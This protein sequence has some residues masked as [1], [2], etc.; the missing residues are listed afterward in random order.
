MS[1]SKFIFSIVLLLILVGGAVA[2]YYPRKKEN[3]KLS[4]DYFPDTAEIPVSYLPV[5]GLNNSYFRGGDYKDLVD[6]P[7][8]PEPPKKE[9]TQEYY[10]PQQMMPESNMG[11]QGNRNGMED[12]G[13]IPN[14]SNIIGINLSK[15]RLQADCVSAT[16]NI[17]NSEVSPIDSVHRIYSDSA[18]YIPNSIVTGTEMYENFKDPSL[19]TVYDNAMKRLEI[20]HV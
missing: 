20:K 2:M 17:F 19:E 7:A 3:F 11:A 6:S 15:H 18:H 16:F 9:Q 5:N 14:Q 12:D 10:S 1:D 4:S 13:E 8:V